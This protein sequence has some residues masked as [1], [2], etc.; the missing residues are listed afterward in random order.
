MKTKWSPEN[1]QKMDVCKKRTRK[2]VLKAS[3]WAS[4]RNENERAPLKLLDDGRLYEK[5]SKGRPKKS[6]KI[7][8]CK[9][10]TRGKRRIFT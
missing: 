9:K 6:Q 10:G 3:R 5:N 7:G 1:C 4:V 8:V 2:G